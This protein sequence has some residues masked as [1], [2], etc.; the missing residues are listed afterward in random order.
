MLKLLEYWASGT[1]VI[2]SRLKGIEEIT[3]DNRDIMF[4][5]PGDP[6]DLAAQILLFL[7]NHT[8]TKRLSLEGRNS[9][10]SFSWEDV[11][12]KTI[13]ICLNYS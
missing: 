4:A 12:H 1:T 2:A 13:D 6:K 10:V 3:R 5:E 11:I 9:V 8:I 7:E